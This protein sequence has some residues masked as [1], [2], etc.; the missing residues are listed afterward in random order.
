[1][2][3]AV[4]ES[5]TLSPVRWPFRAKLTLAGVLIAVLP[6]LALGVVLDRL[7]ARALTHAARELQLAVADDVSRTI[8]AHYASAQSDLDAIARTLLDPALDPANSLQLARTL[9]AA[10]ELLDL[11][12]VY[13]ASGQLVDVLREPQTASLSLPEQ[14]TAPLTAAAVERGA[15]RGEAVPTPLGPRLWLV[16]ALQTEGGNRGYVASLVSLEPLQRRVARLAELR[17]RGA[18]DAVFVIDRQRRILAHPDG[19]Q[20]AAL[21]SAADHGLL[22]GLPAQLGRVHETGELTRADGER[23][24]GSVVGLPDH[25]LAVVVQVPTRVAYASLYT[26]RKVV[27]LSVVL[28][29]ALVAGVALIMA[30]R[31]TRPIEALTQFARALAARDFGRSLELHTRDELSVLAAAMSGAARD[32]AASEAHLVREQ[33]IRQDLGRYLPRD[34]VERVVAR[35]QDMALGG[36]RCTVSVLF[37]D[38][39]AFTPLVER[40][41]AEGTVRIL[42]ELFTMLTEIV[43]RHGGTV[44]KFIGDCVMALWGAPGA[45]ADHARRAIAAAED[46]QSWL[47]SGNAIWQQQ[48]G[49]SLRLAIGINSGE[50]VVGNVGSEL[51]MEYTAIGDVVNVAAR[52]ESIARPSQ[53]LVSAET[54]Q[55]AGDGYTYIDLGPR[56]M[57]GRERPVHVYE[58]RP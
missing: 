7:E 58:V 51:R 18:S 17:F 35:E 11:A 54:R 31:L 46:M 15:A 48:H 44:D 6:V 49:V 38:V 36:A 2:P 23:M 13:D 27:G 47:E 34:L 53:V 24:L 1:M 41:D 55:A 56:P 19:E 10:D 50:A 43:F 33:S 3:E 45:D 12:A 32:L 20:S 16:V 22:R 42:N 9:L 37:A 40:L 8:D 28:V 39:V 21:A 57:A 29:C 30:R 26:L 14:L 25:A 5:S 4:P 52:L